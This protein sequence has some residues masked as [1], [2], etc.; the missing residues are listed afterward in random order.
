[1]FLI[2]ESVYTFDGCTARKKL[3]KHGPYGATMR[4]YE[5]FLT[6]KSG[7]LLHQNLICFLSLFIYLFFNRRLSTRY[8]RLF[9]NTISAVNW[10]GYWKRTS[11]LVIGKFMGNVLG[12]QRIFQNQTLCKRMLDRKF[13]IL[14]WSKI[15]RS[16]TN[17]TTPD[18]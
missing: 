15:I 17:E 18:E 3:R 8:W 13:Q 7:K 1:M 5:D 11:A 4:V 6:Y 16:V 2:A 14:W 9:G 12:E 10:L